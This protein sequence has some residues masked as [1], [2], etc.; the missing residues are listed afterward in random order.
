MENT[1]STPSQSVDHPADG[2]DRTFDFFPIYLNVKG[3]PCL[4]VGG[5]TV[6]QRKVL[7]LIACGAQVHVTSPELTLVLR[8]LAERG[9]IRWEMR[10]YERGEARGHSLVFSCTDH[11]SVNKDVFED[12]EAAGIPCNVVDDPEI[13]S[14]IMPSVL[15]RGPIAIAVSTSGKSPALARAI[16]ERVSE[17]IGSE[18]AV[19]A[20]LISEMR[21]E[22]LDAGEMTEEE[23]ITF[24]RDVTTSHIPELLKA[25]KIE[26]ARALITSWK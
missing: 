25:G 22:M 3:K 26:E 12:C 24:W 1:A 10:P 17:V 13:C 23:R 7:E 8:E 18:Y 15:H 11:R 21:R 4:V 2:A 6:A 5:G 14:F 19:F 9:A 20:E 16:R